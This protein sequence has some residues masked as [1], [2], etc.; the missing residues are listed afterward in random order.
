MIPDT[1]YDV[2]LKFSIRLT[3][4]D[5]I[6]LFKFI[7]RLYSGEFDSGAL[8]NVNLCC[9]YGSDEEFMS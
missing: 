4:R 8:K 2:N 9:E 7:K 3:V 1:R 6:G 5:N